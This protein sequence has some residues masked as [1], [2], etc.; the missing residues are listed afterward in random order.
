MYAKQRRLF[1]QG[2]NRMHSLLVTA[3][4]HLV[5]RCSLHTSIKRPIIFMVTVPAQLFEAFYI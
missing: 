5:H 1:L 2:H 3:P 4:A